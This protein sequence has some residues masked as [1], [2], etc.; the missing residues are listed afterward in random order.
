MERELLRLEEARVQALLRRDFATLERIMAEDCI[1]VESNGTVRT[2]AQ[3]LAAFKA[4]EFTFE[5]FDIEENRVRLYGDTAVVIGRYSNR[6]RTGGTTLPT[7]RARH[8]R[9]YV[10]RAGSWQLVAH[11]ATELPQ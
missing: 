8:L 1:H 9:V 7:K 4:G 5:A 3:F 10:K 11:Q 6:I 2:T